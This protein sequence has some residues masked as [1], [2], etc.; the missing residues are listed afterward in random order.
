MLH[1]PSAEILPE[2][3]LKEQRNSS[4]NIHCDNIKLSITLFY[5]VN[6]ALRNSISPTITLSVFLLTS[7]ISSFNSQIFPIN[8]VSAVSMAELKLFLKSSW[9]CLLTSLLSSGLS[10]KKDIGIS[11]TSSELA[12][13]SEISPLQSLTLTIVS[14]VFKIKNE[15]KPSAVD[16]FSS[17]PD[18]ISKSALPSTS[19]IV[20]LVA[21]VFCHYFVV[22]C[23]NNNLLKFVYFLNHILSF[24]KYVQRWLLL[25]PSYL[26]K[27]PFKD[28]EVVKSTVKLIDS[29]KNLWRRYDPG[30]SVALSF[31]SNWPI[32][33]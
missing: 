26:W 13:L 30:I 14:V 29:S 2:A 12:V 8:L 16:Q 18:A 28:C 3:D 11:W 7:A 1:R 32:L 10:I 22:Y 6:S 24:K 31:L 21:L 5:A 19:S 9:K 33:G 20:Q 15:S 17:F 25:N 4:G 27:V 23:I